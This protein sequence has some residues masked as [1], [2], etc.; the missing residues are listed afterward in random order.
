MDDLS[1]FFTSQ[2]KEKKKTAFSDESEDML[3]EC[4]RQLSVELYRR[5]SATKKDNEGPILPPPERGE[6]ED[7][8]PIEK[9]RVKLSTDD[10][11]KSSITKD[12]WPSSPTKSNGTRKDP[13]VTFLK[14]NYGAMKTAIS[15]IRDKVFQSQLRG[16][17]SMATLD[18]LDAELTFYLENMKTLRHQL[19]EL[20]QLTTYV[21]NGIHKSYHIHE[22]IVKKTKQDIQKHLVRLR[23]KEVDLTGSTQTGVVSKTEKKQEDIPKRKDHFTHLSDDLSKQAKKKN[24]N[25]ECR[26]KTEMYQQFKIKKLLADQ[27]RKFEVRLQHELARKLIN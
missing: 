27:S 23:Q 13:V 1:S 19:A 9:P 11:F 20:P 22:E 17:L 21:K 4:I 10:V 7:L 16:Q 25:D 12:T 3:R 24:C 5:N 14:Q 8:K 2:D 26:R 18:L 6:P 15:N